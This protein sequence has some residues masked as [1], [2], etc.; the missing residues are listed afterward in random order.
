M[1]A[2]SEKHKE[3]TFKVPSVVS[4]LCSE[5]A[6]VDLTLKVCLEKGYDISQKGL[7]KEGFKRLIEVREP[8]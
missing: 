7:R 1:K 6:K 3:V 4:E 2:I 5:H 8:T